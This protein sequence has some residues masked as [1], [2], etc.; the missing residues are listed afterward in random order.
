MT[1]NPVVQAFLHT[2]RSIHA[3]NSIGKRDGL[4]SAS[5]IWTAAPTTGNVAFMKILTTPT[6]KTATSATISLTAVDEFTLWVNN[7]AIGTSGANWKAGQAFSAGLNASA[8]IVAVLAVNKNNAGAPAPGLLATILVT[9]SDGS[10]DTAVSDASWFVS[11]SI[12][13]SFPT[14]SDASKFGPATVLA[15]FGSGSWGSSVTMSSPP[16]NSGI[17]SG[18]QW[19]W[20]TS[21]AASDAATGTVGF[22]RTLITPA[23]KSAQ[24]ATV[25]LTVDN[26][27]TFYLNTK[28]VG[29]PPPAPAMSDFR[30]VQQFTVDLS[31]TSN[32]FTVF[33]SNIPNAGSTDAGPAGFVAAIHITYTDGS[34]ADV[35]TDTNWLSGAFTSVPAFLALPDSALSATFALG[36]M[37]ASPWGQMTAI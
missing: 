12:P 36:T 21:T 34:T 4:T 24:S 22:R 32:V 23:G 17:L 7:Q 28:Y 29:A 13:P 18:S 11:A 1:W 20:S 3:H 33:A 25:L 6:G 16:S 14:V 8:N 30:H 27:F 5:W 26:S 2:P 37:G 10:S 9:Y 15:P 31:A 19:I 35:G